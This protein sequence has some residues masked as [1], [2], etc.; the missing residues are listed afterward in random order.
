ME[1]TVQTASPTNSERQWAAAAHLTA[2][3]LALLTSWLVG[4][5]GV[6]GA[7]IVYLL[8][9]DDSAFVAEH[10]R[11]AVNFNL[12]MLIYAGLALAAGIALVGATVLTLGLGAILT[13]PAG[14]MLLLLMAAIAL[15]WL[16]C[17]IVA[18]IKAW[19]GEPYRY[20]LTIRLLN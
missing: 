18:T 2:L 17:S 20:P 12:S 8:K 5:A 7:G 3:V 13:V 6:V 19:N 11:E 14:I 16:I 10:A 4:V 15:L 1:Y 9:R